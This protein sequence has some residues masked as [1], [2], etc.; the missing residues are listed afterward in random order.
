MLLRE[1]EEKHL[2]HEK[3]EELSKLIGKY[4]DIF[5]PEEDPTPRIKHYIDAGNNPPA[6]VPP[7]RISPPIKELLK[8]ELDEFS[9]NGPIEESES[10]NV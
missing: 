3:R 9:A 5:R 1:S 4:G 2:T 10:L 8:K 7:Y 6:A